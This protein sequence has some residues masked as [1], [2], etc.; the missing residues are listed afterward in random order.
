MRLNLPV[1]QKNHPVDPRVLL[2]STTDAKGR[3]THC[4]Q[5]FVD[6][7]GYRYDE[8]IGQ[9][10]NLIRHPDMPP[11]AFRDLW[12]TLKCGRPWSGIVK[13]RCA[14]GDHYWVHANV[15][16]V[17]EDGRA[18][19]FLSVRTAATDEE[20]KQAEALYAR[21]V[22]E[23]EH[24]TI[25]LHAGRIR[26]VGWRDWP[27]R[28]FRLKLTA[29]MVVSQALVMGAVLAAAALIER[30][31]LPLPHL[32]LSGVAVSASAVMLVGFHRW[33]TQPLTRA[34]NLAAE[35]AGCRLNERLDHDPLSPLGELMRRLDL[36]NLNMRAIVTDVRCEVHEMTDAAD[37]VSRGSLD[38]AARSESQAASVQQTSASMQELTE[39]VNDTARLARELER[40]SETARRSADV[41]GS[42]MSHVTAAMGQIQASSRQVYEIIEVIERIAGQT[43][44]LALNAA[45]EAARAGE[46]GRGFAVVAEEVRALAKRTRDSAS[47]IAQLVTRSAQHAGDGHLRVQGAARAMQDVIQDAEAMARQLAQVTVAAQEQS[48]GIGQV[49]AAVVDLD[50]L[51]QRN[52]TLAQQAAGASRQMT[53]HAA[54]LMRA[55]QIFRIES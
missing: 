45:V 41:G 23:R 54:T 9:P 48:L 3:I 13:N 18:V 24:P 19:S 42:E 47:D 37:E 11:E 25:R 30:W 22:R 32:W 40:L 55:V 51:T 28:V 50:D 43:H 49:N 33:V 1:T 17:L 53:D 14:N 26:R 7:S 29:R 27:W 36:I 12:A 15:T 39:H 31:R 5:A 4:N 8:L 38:L 16:P 6:V 34:Q 21:V 35:V 46:D 52:A 2:V 20:V 10:H 44:L